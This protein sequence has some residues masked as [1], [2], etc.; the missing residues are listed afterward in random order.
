MKSKKTVVISII[1]L[2]IFA[3]KALAWSSI[4]DQES[5]VR[6]DKTWTVKFNLPVDVNTVS[7]NTAYI[8]D[9]GNNAFPVEYKLRDNDTT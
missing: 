5:P 9:T 7:S 1:L 2:L 6:V 3:G 8:T 4:F